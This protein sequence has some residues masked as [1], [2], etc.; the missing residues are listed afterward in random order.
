VT[1]SLAIYSEREAL[2][3]FAGMVEVSEKHKIVMKA[4]AEPEPVG[5]V[6]GLLQRPTLNN[7]ETS[8][9]ALGAFEDAYTGIDTPSHQTANK[10][11]Y[12]QSSLNM[13]NSVA[14]CIL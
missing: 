8:S 6:P 2:H 5:Q 11:D 7:I 12:A 14:H 9:Y 13:H 3:G 10:T 1:G 4:Y